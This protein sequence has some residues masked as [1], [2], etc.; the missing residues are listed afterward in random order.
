MALTPRSDRSVGNSLPTR[1][2]V[3][4]AHEFRLVLTRGQQ[5][6]PPYDVCARYAGT[7]IGTGV[8][9]GVGDGIGAGLGVGAGTGVGVGIGVG[10]DLGVGA[11]AG[12]QV[13]DVIEIEIGKPP[14]AIPLAR[15]PL[16]DR[17]RRAT[18]YR[19]P[20]TMTAKLV[21]VVEDDAAIRDNY[22]AG[23]R[24]LYWDRSAAGFSLEEM[25]RSSTLLLA[26]AVLLSLALSFVNI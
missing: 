13:D 21:A 3:D 12:R 16:G 1:L 14:A 24:H 4:K 6:C 8:G 17:Q 26:L 9:I 18:A 5:S 19:L 25:Q 22:L 7:G 20:D 10:A 15:R 23:L 11:G 2:P